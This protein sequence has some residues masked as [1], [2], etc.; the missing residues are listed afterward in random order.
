MSQD[1][2]TSAQETE[3]STEKK[4]ENLEQQKCEEQ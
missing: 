2:A 3:E 4:T 1:K